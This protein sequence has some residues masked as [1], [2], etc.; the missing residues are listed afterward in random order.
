MDY[1]MSSRALEGWSYVING[2][3]SAYP[4]DWWVSL[5]SRDYVPL[6]VI[7]NRYFWWLKV[8]RKQV[9]HHLENLWLVEKQERGV[10]HIHSVIFGVSSDYSNWKKAVYNWET[11]HKMGSGVKFGDAKIEIFDQRRQKRLSRYL[12]KEFVQYSKEL[13]G[14]GSIWDVFGFSRGVRRHLKTAGRL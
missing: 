8:V 2:C 4:W 13:I 1:C 6:T 14:S 5:S 3:L 9:G 7:K 12:A 11:F 10:F